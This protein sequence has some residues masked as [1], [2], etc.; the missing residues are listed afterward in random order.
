MEVMEAMKAKFRVVALNLGVAL[1]AA[2]VAVGVGELYLRFFRPQPLEAAYMWEDGTLRHIPSFSFTYARQEFSSLV[3]FNALG[4]RGSEIAPDPRPGIPRVL[5]MGD[6][7]VEGKQVGEEEVVTAALQR[8]AA[9][10]GHPIEVINAGVAGYG[11]GEEIL[12]WEQVG[13]ALKPELV[14]LGFYPNDVRNN[15]ERKYFALRDG[16]IVPNRAPRRPKLRWIYD[17]RKLMASR[18]HFYVLLKS[19]MKVMGSN[20]DE[21]E[22]ERPAGAEA[23]PREGGSTGP[24]ATPRPASLLETEDVFEIQ[25]SPSIREGWLLTEALLTEMKR[26]VEARG[27][28][29]ILAIF[30]SRYQVDRALW[31]R[32]AAE[33]GIDPADHDMDLPGRRLRAWGEREGVAVVDP[34]GAFRA[35]NTDNSFYFSVDAHWRPSGHELAAEAI[36]ERLMPILR[37]EEM[38]GSDPGENGSGAY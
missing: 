2:L 9:A 12:L 36:A 6:S 16:R 37:G 19:G 4:L 18:S 32:H 21:D 25:P 3:R 11:T 10:G 27:A 29:F 30:P 14:I 13:P 1:F 8:L 22:P 20:A 35:G 38:G 33:T 34:L 31:E 17:L 28:R 24:P 15:V 23:A 26:R 5:F 7:F